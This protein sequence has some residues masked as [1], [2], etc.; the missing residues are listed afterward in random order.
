M[1]TNMD[2]LFGVEKRNY[3]KKVSEQEKQYAVK[4]RIVKKSRIKK[5]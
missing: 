2:N 5:H 4:K 1:P 3:D